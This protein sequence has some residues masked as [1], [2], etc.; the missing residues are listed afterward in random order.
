M[1]AGAPL[2]LHLTAYPDCAF[3]HICTAPCVYD[4]VVEMVYA[5]SCQ[6][7]MSRTWLK[8]DILAPDVLGIKR[9]EYTADAG[10]CL[11]AVFFGRCFPLRILPL[12]RSSQ[13]RDGQEDPATK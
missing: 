2:T 11:C 7:D 4:A 6:S 5:L 8:L 12:P 1:T 10:E 13:V 9:R 3:H